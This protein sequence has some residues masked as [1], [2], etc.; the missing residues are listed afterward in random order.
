MAADWSPFPTPTMVTR[1]GTPEAPPRASEGRQAWPL[2]VQLSCMSPEQIAGGP[3]SWGWERW[4]LALLGWRY[5]GPQQ[6]MTLR[7]Q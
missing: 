2:S 1:T 3:Q 5:S 6:G 4:P 7:G